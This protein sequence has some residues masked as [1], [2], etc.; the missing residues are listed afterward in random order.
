MRMTLFNG[1]LHTQLAPHLIL[2]TEGTVYKNIDNTK[3]VLRPIKDKIAVDLVVS[4]KYGYKSTTNDKWYFSTSPVDYVEFQQKLYK[5]NR[6]SSFTK[7]IGTTEYNVGI[8]K[9]AAYAIATA[10]GPAKITRVTLTPSTASGNL[11]ASTKLQYKII[12]FNGSGAASEESSVFT[13]TTSSSGV[14]KI[15]ASAIDTNFSSSAVLYRLFDGTWRTVGTFATSGS[16]VVDDVYDIHAN[17]AMP[18][19]TKLN[20][21]Y[22]Y[23]VTFYSSL[24]ADSESQPT[25]S[26]EYTL[27]NGTA[28]LTGLPV[29]AD[30]QVTHIRI[31][32]IG[33]NLTSYTLVAALANGT[34]SYVDSLAD[35]D[36]PG[37]LLQ[38]EDYAVPV[39]G[40]QYLTEANAMLFGAVANKLYFTPIAKPNVWPTLNYLT[41]NRPITGIGKTTI[42]LLVFTQFETYIVTGTGPTSLTQ[43]ILSSDQGCLSHDSIKSVQNTLVWVSSDGVCASTGSTPSVLTRDRLGKQE[44]TTVNSAVYDTQY[45]LQLADGTTFIIDF[46]KNV[47]KTADYNVDALA[48]ADDTLYG[49]TSSALYKLEHATTN[50]SCAYRSP[51]V[52]ADGLTKAKAYKTIYFSIDGEVQV[53]VYIDNK[54]VCTKSFNAVGVVDVKVPVEQLRGYYISFGITGT[55]VVNEITWADGDANG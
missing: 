38:S 36:L 54:L 30:A 6:S 10:S 25:I 33:G 17:A 42:G 4:G 39:T 21:T 22:S 12:N 43:Q 35:V 48:V 45:Y 7:L 50:L 52:A 44:F 27:V 13:V 41:F 46:N 24:D 19:P 29:S 8:A 28:T 20:G 49:L 23:A 31:Y 9:P 15:T 16:T 26:S 37:D 53:Q 32:R 3:G 55:G 18:D 34:T 1:G 51:N 11:P 2:P 5:T 47:F 14:G 40:L